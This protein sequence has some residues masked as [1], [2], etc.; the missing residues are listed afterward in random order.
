MLKIP[1]AVTTHV[2]KIVMPG[3]R[4]SSQVTHGEWIDSKGNSTREGR[5]GVD[6]F[7][8]TKSG[9]DLSICERDED[10]GS[11]MD[12]LSNMF[13]PYMG[14]GTRGRGRGPYL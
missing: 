3:S 14:R 7:V 5:G 6:V 1:C 9:I 2:Y 13:V 4:S 10:D 11:E 8:F 12:N